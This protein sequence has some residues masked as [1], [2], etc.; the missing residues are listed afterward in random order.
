MTKRH[1]TALTESGGFD[2]D[3]IDIEFDLVEVERVY[4]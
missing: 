4:P 2:F 3:P 1:K